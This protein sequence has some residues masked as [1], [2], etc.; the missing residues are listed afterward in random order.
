VD[1]ER[2]VGLLVEKILQKED[3]LPVF[4]ASCPAF[5]TAAYVNTTVVT[6]GRVHCTADCSSWGGGWR[7]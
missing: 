3:W 2:A 4:F 7:G 5:A 1:L 6:A